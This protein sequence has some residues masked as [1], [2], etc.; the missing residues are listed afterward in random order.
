MEVSKYPDATFTL[1]QPV[2]AAVPADGQVATVQANRR[3]HHARRHADRHRAAAGRAPGDGVQVSGSI[4]VTFSDYGV[5]APS[6][7]FVSVE[8][9]G[10]VEFLVK[11]TPT[12]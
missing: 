12:K 4:P 8:D 9:Q 7:G 6:L 1:T 10:T 11:A 5:Q 3:A 2:D